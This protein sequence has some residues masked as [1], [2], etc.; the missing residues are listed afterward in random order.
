MAVPRDIVRAFGRE[1]RGP[2][3]RTVRAGHIAGRDREAAQV[4]PRGGVRV[5][6]ILENGVG[7]KALRLNKLLVARLGLLRRAA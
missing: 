2:G 5:L 1:R 6:F 7:E 3:K 4:V